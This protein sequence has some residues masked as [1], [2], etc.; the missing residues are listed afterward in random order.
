MNATNSTADYVIADLALADWAA[1]K[2][3]LPKP[4]CRA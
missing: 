4:K 3:V 1:R 2:S